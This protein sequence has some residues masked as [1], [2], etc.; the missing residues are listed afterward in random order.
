MTSRRGLRPLSLPAIT[1]EAARLVRRRPGLYFGLSLPATLPLLFALVA[2]LRHVSYFAGSV[3]AYRPILLRH[4]LLIGLLLV[5]RWISHGAIC[6][7]AAA[8]LEGRPVELGE[9]W[10]AALKASPSLVFGGLLAWGL[11][12]FAS[13]MFIFPGLFVAGLLASVP[14]HVMIEEARW[15]GILRQAMKTQSGS[16]I[17]TL[18]LQLMLLVGLVI[19]VAGLMALVPFALWLLKAAIPGQTTWLEQGLSTGNPIYVVSMS[20]IGLLIMEPVRIIAQFR[21]ALDGKIRREGYDLLDRVTRLTGVDLRKAALG[22]LL[23]LLLLVGAGH[24]EAEPLSVGRYRERLAE[25]RAVVKA[26]LARLDEG[27]ELETAELE[28]IEQG[29]RDLQV[30]RGERVYSLGSG[31]MDGFAKSLRKALPEAAIR[32]LRGLDRRLE[33][34]DRGA[35]SIAGADPRKTMEVEQQVQDI[36]SQSRFQ[37]RARHRHDM[38]RDLST[39]DST[40]QSISNWLSSFKWPRM[41]WLKTFG[42]WVSSWFK[43]PKFNVPKVA[44]GFAGFSQIV[45]V[46]ILVVVLALVAWA[47][48][49]KLNPGGEA[50]PEVTISMPAG[51]YTAPVVAYETT[52]ESWRSDARRF[53]GGGDYPLAVRSSYAGL[54]L[55]LNR[56]GWIEFDKTRTNWEYLQSVKRRNK[57][58]ARRMRPLTKVFDEKWYGKK[59]CTEEDY[60]TFRAELDRVVREVDR[61][62]DDGDD[63]DGE[64]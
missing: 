6:H 27:E 17:R 21:L 64:A 4:S 62:D 15:W 41:T 32:K 2:Y 26:Q 39:V 61:G 11:T 8:E 51:G 18:E 30:R 20:V 3:E 7:A 57:T 54:L 42:D 37:R 16:V 40:L 43:M 12:G 59:D 1:D 36:L 35:R 31:G 45:I 13:L 58:I 19:G 22:L 14:F 48:I 49:R 24:A 55:T 9:A 47:I 28:R 10:K 50:V 29:L 56:L 38:P 23:P 53:A 52:E 46:V 63:R 44:S 34:L 25:A 5:L 60:Q 33:T